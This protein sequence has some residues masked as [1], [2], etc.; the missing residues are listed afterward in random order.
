MSD[1]RDELGRIVWKYSSLNKSVDNGFDAKVVE[2]GQSL[3][4][5]MEMDAAWCS[6]SRSFIRSKCCIAK[7]R[8]Q[9][10]IGSGIV[11]VRFIK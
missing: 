11:I 8:F 2:V 1:F 4:Y 3:P 6:K 7:I 10:G 9:L 5:M